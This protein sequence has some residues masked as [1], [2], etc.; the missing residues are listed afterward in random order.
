[1][2]FLF[3]LH[4]I[5][6]SF[7]TNLRAQNWVFI[8]T[9]EKGEKTYFNNSDVTTSSNGV[10]SGWTKFT[11]YN[12]RLNQNGK[13]KIIPSVTYFTYSEFN[14]TTKTIKD[15]ML[16]VKDNNGNVLFNDTKKEW[17]QTEIY[18]VPGTI[19]ESL[20]KHLCSK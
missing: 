5:I 15:I 19:S 12:Y 10:K 4:I 14:C 17:Q 7:S 18:A 1:M 9:S 3:L 20:I 16:I 8:G 11:K 6:L 13:V 2:K